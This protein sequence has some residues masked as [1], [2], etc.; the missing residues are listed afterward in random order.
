MSYFH[1]SPIFISSTPLWWNVCHSTYRVPTHLSIPLFKGCMGGTWSLSAD[2]IDR[3]EL[4][5]SD[6]AF[7]GSLLFNFLRSRF[8]VRVNEFLARLREV[9]SDVSLSS[10]WKKFFWGRATVLFCFFSRCV[11][12]A[13]VDALRLHE[14]DQGTRRW[15]SVGEIITRCR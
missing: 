3:C 2:E 10:S 5:L 15:C 7:A 4:R 8:L 6:V 13:V 11:G 1:S 14:S 9:G 12:E